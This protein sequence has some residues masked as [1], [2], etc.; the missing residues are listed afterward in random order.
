LQADQE[1]N[2]INSGRTG[3]N[4]NDT[5]R[6][7]TTSSLQNNTSSFQNNT[8]SFQNSGSTNQFYSGIPRSN[9]KGSDLIGM[10]VR[11]LQGDRI[12]KVKDLVVDLPSG[13]IA[14][15]VLSTGPFN[16]RLLA[17]P[18][19]ALTASTNAKELMLDADKDRLN[20][21][22]GFEKDNWPDMGSRTWETNPFW[23]APAG[24][25][26]HRSGTRTSD[27]T[28]NRSGTSTG[29]PNNNSSTSNPNNNF[30]TSNPN[31]NNS[32]TS[33]PNNPGTNPN[34]K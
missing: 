18:P 21:A 34:P 26:I 3:N 23:N 32:N 29:N 30:N 12:A 27:D 17:V 31:N 4:I 16:G 14:Y 24:S 7:N 11:N 9:N 2:R 6:D 20:S 19:S 13:R 8:S 22:T 15:V 33:N 5:R 10:E 28:F 25:D 1:E